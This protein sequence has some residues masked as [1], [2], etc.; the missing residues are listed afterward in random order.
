MLHY[1]SR[2]RGRGTLAGALVASVLALGPLVVAPLAQGDGADSTSTT[3][4]ASA[5][6]R[7]G[8]DVVFVAAGGTTS[9]VVRD[10]A[11]PGD[12]LVFEHLSLPEGSYALSLRYRNPGPTGATRRV[13]TAGADPVLVPLPPTG[14]SWSDATWASATMTLPMGVPFQDVRV[15]NVDGRPV[16]IESLALE[17]T[18]APV[19]YEAERM[20]RLGASP[21][22]SLATEPPAVV[23]WER[24]GD[25]LARTVAL[26]GGQYDVTFRYRN[27]TTS[28]VTREVRFDGVR[29]AVVTLAPSVGPDTAWH[30]SRARVIVP[31]GVATMTIVN[32]DDRPVELDAVSFSILGATGGLDSAAS[33]TAARPST[34]AAGPVPLPPVDPGRPVDGGQRGAPTATAPASGGPGDTAGN[35]GAPSAT[36]APAPDGPSTRG[37]P[38]AVPPTGGPSRGAPTATVP[39][40]A[41]R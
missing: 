14:S 13:E 30:E 38:N 35:R 31:G 28:A 32:V 21:R 24:A 41:P 23:G 3:I 19:V 36:P 29:R 5:A 15:V 22:V 9:P 27:P 37:A 20:V 33:T 25:A 1:R 8:S 12:A 4:A 6:R 34:P 2:V 39:G 16:E 7:E 10:G 26:P 18:R 11:Q 40:E 17:A